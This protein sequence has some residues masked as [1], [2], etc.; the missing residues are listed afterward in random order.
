MG[1]R[2]LVD[3]RAYT[4][5]KLSRHEPPPEED[6]EIQKEKRLWQKFGLAVS[7]LN[8]TFAAINENY[9]DD[10]HGQYER[11]IREQQLR[12]LEQAKSKLI[13]CASRIRLKEPMPED[14]D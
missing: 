1:N 13:L 8:E 12:L 6:E 4:S 11:A 3:I 2:K 14:V 7:L 9:L 5:P 10:C